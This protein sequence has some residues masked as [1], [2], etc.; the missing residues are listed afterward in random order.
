MASKN[1]D[2]IIVGSGVGGLGTAAILAAKEGKK[3]LVLEK[4]SFIGGRILSFYGKDNEVWI[5][6]KPYEYKDFTKALGSTGTWI[7]HA[8]PDFETLVKKGGFNGYIMDGGHGL[9]WGDKGR[10]TFL[11]KWLGKPIYMKV[12]KGFG[13][14]DNKDQTKWYQVE[15]GQPYPWMSDGGKATRKILREIATWSFE[16]IEQARGSLGQF[17]RE[18]NCEEEAWLF[19]RNLAGSQT[20]MAN[21]DDM[22]MRDYLKYQAIAKDIGMDL[23]T[24]S[25]ATI[26]AG[27]GILDIAV[28]L[29]DLIVENGGEVWTESPVEEIIIENKKV[30]GVKVKTDRG[31]ETVESSLVVC[32]IP[33]KHALKVIPEKHFPADFYSEVK[34]KYYIPGLLTG[35]YYFNEDYPRTKGIDPRSFTFLSGVTKKKGMEWLDFVMCSMTWWANVAPIGVN[36]WLFSIPLMNPEM[37]DKKMVDAC[38][39][40]VERFLTENWPKW[41]KDLVC[42]FWTAGSEAYG[43]WRPIGKDRPYSQAPWA[44]GLYFAGDQ[45]GEK[46]WGGGVDGAALSAAL[47]VDAIT[48]GD[49]E[50]QI[51]PEYHRSSW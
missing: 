4:E 38:I 41:R 14:V 11:L 47:C 48:G 49:Y 37:H 24:G 5:I 50:S 6:D 16:Q 45:Y 12:N 17:L 42:S 21:P 8:Q 36:G 10:I 20:A 23:I 33:P 35:F 1:Y 32:N 7:T 28:Q 15:H 51:F 31:S 18:R 46:M 27:V 34:D 22:H 26:D 30:K 2:A 19:I 29:K 13:I 9:F 40:E 44:E 39:N 25:V 3:V 43:H